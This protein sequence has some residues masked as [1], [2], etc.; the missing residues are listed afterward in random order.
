MLEFWEG[1]KTELQTSKASKD[2]VSGCLL[3]QLGQRA[4]KALQ[5]LDSEETHKR[6]NA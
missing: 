5:E 3:S 1:V 2:E 4:K 6:T